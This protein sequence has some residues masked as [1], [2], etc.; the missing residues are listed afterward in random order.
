MKITNIR[1]DITDI[2]AKTKS[3]VTCQHSR[4]FSA[5][6]SPIVSTVVWILHWFKTTVFVRRKLGRSFC[7]CILD[8][9]Y[10]LTWSYEWQSSTCAVVLRGFVCCYVLSSTSVNVA[11]W[12][13]MH[14]TLCQA[15][16]IYVLRVDRTA[17]Q[18]CD[19]QSGGWYSLYMF[20]LANSSFVRTRETMRESETTRP[21][22]CSWT[23]SAVR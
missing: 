12:L 16:S 1:G 8:C 21:A 17:D 3:L 20:A 7:R 6:R 19:P 9:W 11:G 4:R 14:T 15:E 23:N 2:S 22:F 18:S 5:A 10:V 13:S